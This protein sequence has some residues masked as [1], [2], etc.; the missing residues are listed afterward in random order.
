M[1]DTLGYSGL[2]G[3]GNLRAYQGMSEEEKAAHRKSWEDVAA[4]T[5]TTPAEDRAW[6]DFYDKMR[7]TGALLEFDHRQETGA[8]ARAA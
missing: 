7:Q 1:A 4:K 6:F 5:A 2:L 8:A 3:E